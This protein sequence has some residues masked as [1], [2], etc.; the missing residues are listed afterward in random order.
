MYQSWKMESIFERLPCLIKK[1]RAPRRPSFLPSV[2]HLQLLRKSYDQVPN[3]ISL[4]DLSQ[5]LKTSLGLKISF[6]TQEMTAAGS[7][8]IKLWSTR[9]NSVD[10]KTKFYSYRSASCHNSYSNWSTRPAIILK[11]VR[12]WCKS[13]LVRRRLKSL[14]FTSWIQIG[15]ERISD[16]KFTAVI[17]RTT[18]SW[19]A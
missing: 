12:S 3:P 10:G 15:F 7:R 6:S 2:L 17:R 18:R 1:S 16:G 11:I 5:S 4:I 8:S 13:A 14:R 9:L 19:Q